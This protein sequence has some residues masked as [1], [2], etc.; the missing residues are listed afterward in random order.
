MMEVLDKVNERF[1]KDTLRYAVQGYKKN[2]KLKQQKLS[3]CYTTNIM[4]VLAI[5][6]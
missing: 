5:K 4:E 3:P 1:G 6:I 2:W